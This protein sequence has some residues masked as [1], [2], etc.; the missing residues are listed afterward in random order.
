MKNG[1][2]LIGLMMALVMLMAMSMTSFAADITID[3]VGS[4]YEAYKLLNATDGGNGKFAY[5]VND[6]YLT[7]LQNETQKT[8]DKDIVAYISKLNSTATRDF[9]DAVYQKIEAASLTADAE[10]TTKKFSGVDQGYYLIVEAATETGNIQDPY[11]LVM[12]DTAGNDEITIKAKESQPTL[13]KQIQHNELGTWQEVGDNQIGDTVNF[14]LVVTVPDFTADYTT[15]V[16]KIHDIMS[17]GLTCSIDSDDDVT[18]KKHNDD[19]QILAA[20]YYNV[21]KVGNGFEIDIDVKK[22]VSDNTLHHGHQLFIYYSATVNGNAIVQTDAQTNTAY[23]EY[24]NNPY[25]D[26]TTETEKDTVYDWTFEMNLEKIDGGA[27]DP[28]NARLNGAKFVLSKNGSLAVPEYDASKGT[29]SSTTDL[30]K[31]VKDES[32]NTYRIATDSDAPEKTTYVIDAGLATIKG[33]DDSTYYYLY[34]VKAPN[35]FNM[36]DKPVLVEISSSYNAEGNS[37]KTSLS[38]NNAKASSMVAQVVNNSGTEL[39]ETG[40]IGTQIFYIAGGILLVGALVVLI[41]RRRMNA[42]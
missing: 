18:I 9:A 41:T 24:S 15:Y 29:L 8:S 33:L 28:A 32:T 42:E 38:V 6:K 21:T 16:Y 7:I 12:L 4:K 14:R 37:L 20:D 36:L 25:D 40:G 22:G 27:V 17:D 19:T 2:K 30:I 31:V 3:G 10:T 13:D 23:L 35:G 5:T 11:S 39:P 34:E 26:T 1:K